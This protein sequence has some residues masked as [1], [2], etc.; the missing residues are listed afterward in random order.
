MPTYI[1]EC[2]WPEITE[3][4]AEDA[5]TSIMRSQVGVDPHDQVRPIGGFLMAS[6]GM[7][8]FLFAAPSAATVEAAG[9]MTALP[10]DR[11]VE[12]LQVFVS[13]DGSER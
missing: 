6:D 11:I 5:L 7:A 8:F 3:K 12:S 13:N 10:F 9:E 1:V 4:Q 2:Y